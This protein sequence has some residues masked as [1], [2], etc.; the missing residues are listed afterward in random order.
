METAFLGSHSLLINR[1]SRIHSKHTGTMAAAATIRAAPVDKFA[2]AKD[3]F[4]NQPDGFP[5]DGFNPDQVVLPPG[6]DCGV[7]SDDDDIGEEDIQNEETGFSTSI[8][9]VLL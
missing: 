9:M 1:C 3:M 7:I 6:D 5:Y 2:V 8:G 4:F